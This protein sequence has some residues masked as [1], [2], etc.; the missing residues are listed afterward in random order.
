MSL[1]DDVS[2]VVTPNGYKAGTLYGVLPV[3]TEGS[4]LITNGGFTADAVWVKS[5]SGVTI[6][7]SGFAYFTSGQDTYVFQSIMTIEKQYSI[8][9]DYNI[10]SITSGYFGS[11]FGSGNAILSMAGLSGS[12]T[13][14]GIITATSDLLIIRSSTF[15]GTITN[16]SVKEYTASDM[17]VTRATAGTRV[18]EN[19][20]VNYAEV[21]GS[22][23]IDLTTGDT[24]DASSWSS[25]TTSSVTYLAGGSN[26]S[27][28]NTGLIVTSGLTYKLTF[29]ISSYT[30]TGSIGFSTTAGVSSDARLTT[31][32]SYTEYFVAT[33]SVELRL[34]GL[35]TNAGV[36]SNVSVKEVTRN[37]V[38]RIDYTGG[39]CPHILAE[40]QRTNLLTYSEDFSQ[41]SWSKTSGGTGSV[42]VITSNNVISPDGT[43]NATRIVFNAGSGT[44]NS[45]KSEISSS[46]TASDNT[47]ATASIYLK[48]LNG[49][50]Q[51]VFRGVAS[52][53]YTLI[54]LTTEW[55]RF[56][57]TEDSGTSN[58]FIQFGIRQ[59]VSGHGVINANPTIFAWGSQIEEGSYATSY[60]PTSGSTVTR[61]QD[62]FTRDGISSLIN[63]IAGVF[64]IEMATFLD[65]GTTADKWI[66]LSDGTANNSV[67]IA[68]SGGA[69]TIRAYLNVGGSAQA[70]M[71]YA[72]TDVTQFS[73]IAFSYAAN[74][75]NLWVDGVK[76]VTDTSGSVFSANTLNRLG[77][78]NG[79]GGS[80][81][82]KIK[83]LQVYKTAL[84]DTQLAALTS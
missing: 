10:T 23:N 1:L 43:Q 39:G 56:S 69:N 30:G 82:G 78:D 6:D 71:T 13:L 20:L 80:F 33:S 60:I 41:S 40:P 47:N 83:Q 62:L 75:F 72:V 38:P 68:Y 35:T 70:D 46:V 52:S 25:V 66:A 26:P 37:N 8:T 76:R 9:L 73:K 45:D 21:L 44:S 58:D 57:T 42:P 49:G 81:P 27:Y 14:S 24:L 7:G 28:Y 65:E 51:L 55:Q 67:R 5:P 59:S 48:G 3:P 54:T 15:D 79:G 77:L 11:N 84:T 34:F 2:I 12:G 19:G 22:E 64:F 61:N 16:V 74:N 4:E 18:D 36:F 31:D 29:T 53:T 32:D 63:S 17:D 50:E